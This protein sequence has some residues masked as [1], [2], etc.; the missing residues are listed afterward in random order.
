M[1]RESG[2]LKQLRQ[3]IEDLEVGLATRLDDLAA[4]LEATQKDLAAIERHF[5]RE[6]RSDPVITGPLDADEEEG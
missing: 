3:Y 6:E 5:V 1:P 4:L 2:Q